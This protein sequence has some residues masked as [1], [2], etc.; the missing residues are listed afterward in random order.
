MNQQSERL[1]ALS[2]AIDNAKERDT[3][4]PKI[5]AQIKE[6]EKKRMDRV[7]EI[8]REAMLEVADS[9]DIEGGCKTG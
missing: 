9:E 8:L 5:N 4:I 1:D 6:L 3:V 2:E 7:M